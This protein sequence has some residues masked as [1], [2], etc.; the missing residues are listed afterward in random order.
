[1]HHPRPPRSGYSLLELTLAIALVGGTLA[2]TLSL[3]RSGMQVSQSTDEQLLLTNYA[4]RILEERL[5]VVSATWSDASVTGDFAA[6]GFA[7]VRYTLSATDD[8]GGGGVLDELTHVQVTTYL[9][10]NSNDALDS[11]EPSCSFRTK[12]ANLNS[13]VEKAGA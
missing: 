3:L 6:D 7:E 13:Y 8:P 9:D 5:A 1:M 11:G 10:E 12:V 2:P 4:I